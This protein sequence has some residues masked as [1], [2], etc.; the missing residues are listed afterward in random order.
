[1]NSGI[2]GRVFLV[3]CPRSGT[4]LL[5]SL[6]AAHSRIFS[7]PETHFFEYL[8]YE[9]KLLSFWGLAN[10]RARSRWN[11]ILD[12]LE[13]PEMQ[14][15]LPK[16]SLFV[17]Q[18]SRAYIDT[19]DTLALNQGK[20]I[21][22]DKTPGNLRHIDQIDGLVR[23]ARFIHILRDG[24]DV[25]ASLR[26]VTGQYPDVWGGEWSIEKCVQ[27]WQ[28]DI[29]LSNMYSTR[30]NHVLI[31]YE[32]LVA[33][34]KDVLKGLCEFIKVPF[35]EQMLLNYSTASKQIILK[36]EPWKSTTGQPIRSTHDTKFY[37]LFDEEQRQYILNL[38]AQSPSQFSLERQMGDEKEDKGRAVLAQQE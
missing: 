4:T 34:T 25:V 21:W 27:R 32:N 31:H 14:A 10:W 1:M 35:E 3:G 15:K 7:F 12:E 23:N 16:L 28:Q 11:R 38:L 26:E 20:K 5:Q 36:N 22:L 29:K 2:E 17:R 33:E 8:F 6:L 24:A 30:R 9:K 18:F 13:H 19:L 37:K